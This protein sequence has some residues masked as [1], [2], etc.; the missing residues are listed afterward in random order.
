VMDVRE[1]KGNR[2]ICLRNPWGDTEWK[3]RWSDGSDEWSPEML[4]ALGYKFQDNGT[5]FMCFDDWAL[6]FNKL[7]VLRYPGRDK[8]GNLEQRYDFKGE[9]KG[10]NAGG[11]LN[12]PSWHQNPQYRIKTTQAT[13]ILISLRQADQR[14]VTPL[15]RAPEQVYPTIGFFIMKQRSCD[16]YKQIACGNSELVFFTTY[17]KTREIT[18]EWKAEANTSYILVPSTYRS[19]IETSYCLTLFSKK[20]VDA[21][22]LLQHDPSVNSEKLKETFDLIE[23]YYTCDRCEQEIFDIRWHCEACTDYD[24]CNKC[25]DN[26]T[27]FPR[28]HESSHDMT[29]QRAPH[30]EDEDHA[31]REETDKAHFTALRTSGEVEE[32]LK[33]D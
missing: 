27:L 20:A 26:E 17:L 9:W 3:G 33:D 30:K 11:C 6:N 1:V 14:R 19:R 28:P 24:L 15:E 7:Y 29:W 18:K 21:G 22:E 4:Q 10:H 13:K 23:I 12:V 31:S 25:H 2:L 5:F 16:N 32:S 8:E